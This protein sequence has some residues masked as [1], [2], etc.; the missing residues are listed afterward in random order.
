MQI[1]LKMH[2]MFS[3]FDIFLL[4]AAGKIISEFIS[5]IP[6][7]L[8]DI[9]TIIAINTAKKDFPLN[10]HLFLYFFYKTWFKLT[11]FI[12]LNK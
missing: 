8:I 4:E 10:S 9:I 6:T 12:L 5:N 3:Y 7:H 11:A 2:D 1:K